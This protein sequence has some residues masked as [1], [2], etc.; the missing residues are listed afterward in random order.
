MIHT[1][2]GALLDGKLHHQTLGTGQARFRRSRDRSALPPVTAGV[3][4]DAKTVI[5]LGSEKVTGGSMST[6][7][8]EHWGIRSGNGR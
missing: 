8:Q 7:F 1:T 6:Y 2:I 4:L 5:Y 3:G